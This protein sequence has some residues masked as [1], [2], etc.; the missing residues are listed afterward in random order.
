MESLLD[1]CARPFL[2]NFR[3]EV[4]RL[5]S[6]VVEIFAQERPEEYF[7]ILATRA[8]W[9]S[10][11]VLDRTLGILKACVSQ[12]GVGQ[13]WEDVWER[14]QH[15]RSRALTQAVLR[16]AWDVVDVLVT[17]WAWKHTDDLLQTLRACMFDELTARMAWAALCACHPPEEW[18]PQTRNTW[19]RHR[20]LHSWDTIPR[21]ED[22]WKGKRKP[23][24]RDVCL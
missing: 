22:V 20:D 24:V 18:N 10:A 17:S 14:I 5:N 1:R 21:W 6:L 15:R 16:H 12:L 11:K 7:A 2:S 19:R 13:T 4:F 3:D 23:T 8:A 9:T